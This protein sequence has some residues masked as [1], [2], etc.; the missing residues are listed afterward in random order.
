MEILK[1]T[2]LILFSSRIKLC[3]IFSFVLF[4]LFQNV[5]FNHQLPTCFELF[6][7]GDNKFYQLH[8]LFFLEKTTQ[9]LYHHYFIK[10]ITFYIK[11]QVLN[12][13]NTLMKSSLHCPYC[14]ILLPWKL[15]YLSQ[16]SEC[17]NLYLGVSGLSNTGRCI[18][19][20]IT[21]KIGTSSFNVFNRSTSERLGGNLAE[22]ER[23]SRWQDITGVC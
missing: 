9:H 6:V 10:E 7:L 14:L 22:W 5:F 1:F 12:W 18:V 17:I 15:K 23:G 20:R 16:T 4:I 19:P 11:E 3:N 2:P 13:K 21:E 8:Y